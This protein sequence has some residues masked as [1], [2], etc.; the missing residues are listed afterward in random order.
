M[1][2]ALLALALA[3]P[4]AV[5]ESHIADL[6]SDDFATRRHA[7]AAL[8]KLGDA[9]LPA[10]LRHQ[11]DEDAEVRHRVG[12]L[13]E[14]YHGRAG[15]LLPDGW[16][17]LPYVDDLGNLPVDSQPAPAF[18]AY[19]NWQG[20]LEAAGGHDDPPWSNYRA[21]T[22]LML[23][24]LSRAGWSRGQMRALLN[25]MAAWEKGWC[26]RQHYPVPFVKPLKP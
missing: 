11:R 18:A 14:A 4:G 10:L 16:T 12:M 25:R 13:I 9:A 22:R 8:L 21:A 15:D 3:V 20:Y 5:A 26:E 17:V 24:D 2:A 23:M 1:F 19:R 7:S 6:G